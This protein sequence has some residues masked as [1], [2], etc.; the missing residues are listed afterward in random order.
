[1]NSSSV[2]DKEVLLIMVLA[3]GVLFVGFSWEK[4]SIV[5]KTNPVEKLTQ[6]LVNNSYFGVCTYKPTKEKGL[7]FDQHFAKYWTNIGFLKKYWDKQ[8]VF[9]KDQKLNKKQIYAIESLSRTLYGEFRGQTNEYA[10]AAGRIILNRAEFV[11]RNAAPLKQTRGLK[12]FVRHPANYEAL[13]LVEIIPYVVS[14]RSQFSLWNWGDPNL[15]KSLC[16]RVSE[17]VLGRKAWAKAIKVAVTMVMETDQFK[18]DTA[19]IGKRDYFYTSGNIK[20]WKGCQKISGP[21]SVSK[22][23]LSQSI[24]QRWR[25][26]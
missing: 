25:C 20:P 17:G 8:T 4:K 7:A 22:Q 18:A 3:L 6:K 24:F 15:K 11:V 23:K 16:P 14:S 13:D 21:V 19:S 2:S 1:M 10:M 9:Y 26:S 5:E 12:G